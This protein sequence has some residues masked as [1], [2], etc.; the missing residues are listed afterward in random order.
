MITVREMV[1]FLEDAMD[2]PERLALDVERFQHAVFEAPRREPGKERAWLELEELARELAWYVPDKEL[3]REDDAFLGPRRAAQRI[4]SV[5]TKLG[6]S[7]E[8]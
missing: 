6:E 5:L 4:R 8:K 1:D 3:R 7:G 2:H